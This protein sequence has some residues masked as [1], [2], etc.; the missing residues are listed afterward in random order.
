MDDKEPVVINIV[1]EVIVAIIVLLIVFGLVGGF[2]QSITDRYL[3]FIRGFYDRDWGSFAGAFKI[4]FIIT[5]ILLVGFVIYT[6]RRYQA[7]LRSSPDAE[8]E[9][10][11]GAPE[12]EVRNE[13]GEIKKL[14]V[15]RNPSEWNM[16]V[17][18]ADALLDRVVTLRGYS[19]ISFADRLKIMD[20]SQLPSLD[21]VWSA[22]RLRNMIAHD[23]T[24]SQTQETI[25]HAL[26]AYEQALREL[27]FLEKQNK[28][29]NAA[30][31]VADR[32]PT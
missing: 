18:R 14:V 6:H 12:E 31:I 7:L 28:E 17:L 8:V 26:D 24:Q 2:L 11:I 9:V 16:A 10:S 32:D 19:G 23:P 20:P 5:D 15:S 1:T 29:R 30:D 22:H 4:L 25:V 21:R 27:G 3:N 13:W